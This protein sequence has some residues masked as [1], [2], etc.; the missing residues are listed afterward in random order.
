MAWY[1]ISF[2]TFANNKQIFGSQEVLV[3]G[4]LTR[5]SLVGIRQV[6]A[7]NAGINLTKDDIVILNIVKLDG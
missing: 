2:Y 5:D 4:G 1:Y 7:D 3:Q 6:I